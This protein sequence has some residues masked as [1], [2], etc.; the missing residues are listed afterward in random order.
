VK[1]CRNF[2]SNICAIILRTTP[3][4]APHTLLLF[5]SS[6][7]KWN[8]YWRRKMFW[9]IVELKRQVLSLLIL[10]YFEMLTLFEI[11]E[12]TDA[13]SIFL[14]LYTYITILTMT[15]QD[16]QPLYVENKRKMWLL[17]DC[18]NHIC[19]IDWVWRLLTIH[20]SKIY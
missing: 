1:R 11:T 5:F 10:N 20:F 17:S 9:N 7:T 4:E 6:I 12:Q 18:L 19:F 15:F 2:N 3:H 8:I 13:F 16:R 14:N